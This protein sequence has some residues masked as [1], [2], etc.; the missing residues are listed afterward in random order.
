MSDTPWQPAPMASGLLCESP[1][2]F[3]QW[4]RCGP[5][6]KMTPPR[7]LRFPGGGPY[8]KAIYASHHQ[9]FERAAFFD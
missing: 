5:A 8:R 9:L 3:S 2:A 6:G 4:P 7:R 1:A